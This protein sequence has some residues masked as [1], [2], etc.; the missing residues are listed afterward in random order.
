MKREIRFKGKRIDGKGWAFGCLVY[1][2]NGR[3][4]IVPQFKDNRKSPYLPYTYEVDPETV[5]QFTGLHDQNG[6]EI[7]EGDVVKQVLSWDKGHGIYEYED[8]IAEVTFENGAWRAKEKGFNFD[9][10]T[11][12]P[13]LLYEGIA[14]DNLYEIIGS[15]HTTP[16]GIKK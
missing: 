12:E 11:E 1:G 15:I 14:E 6:N 16:E 9:K 5:C 2:E 7:Y 3:A 13:A 10:S 4:L 8:W